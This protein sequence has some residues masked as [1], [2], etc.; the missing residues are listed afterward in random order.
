MFPTVAGHAFVVV[1]YQDHW[2]WIDNRDI[3][4]KRLFSFLMFIFT[5]VETGTKEAPAVIT[6][7]TG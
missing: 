4:S 5:L 1:P 2:F 7:P 6:I 3:P